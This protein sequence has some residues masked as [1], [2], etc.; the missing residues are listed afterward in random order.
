VG[1][2][3]SGRVQTGSFALGPWSS[4]HVGDVATCLLTLAQSESSV[5]DAPMLRTI[6]SLHP[7]PAQAKRVHG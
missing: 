1:G 5:R 4:A 7:A 3:P 2:D 6:R